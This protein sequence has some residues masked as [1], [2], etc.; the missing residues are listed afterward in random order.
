[1]KLFK[2]MATTAITTMAVAAM[3]VSASAMTATYTAPVGDAA[4][5]VTLS[6]IATT[7]EQ[8]TLLILNKDA[9]NVVEGDIVQIDQDATLTSVAVGDLA[10]AIDAANQTALEAYEAGEK[11]ADTY[12][13][14]TA[15]WKASTD[16]FVRVGGDGSI[17]RY[18]LTVNTTK[19][20]P[21]APAEVPDEPVSQWGI[22]D[23]N[24]SG[25]IPDFVD[26][27]LILA[28][29][30][31][32]EEFDEEQLV[33]GDVN[34]SG[35]DPDFVDAMEILAFDNWEESCLDEYYN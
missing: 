17:E 32:E 26:A 35:G 15:A 31:W 23:V 3:S 22:G 2:L 7:A 27:M 12:A 16:Y 9:E 29:D 24:K 6:D 20:L 19:T 13:T 33:L 21:E 8:K 11:N 34:K 5:S 4:G 30:N 14:L 18:T 1:M 25:D 28:F 10:A